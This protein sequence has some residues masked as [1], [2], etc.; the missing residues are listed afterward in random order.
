MNPTATGYEA[1]IMSA[2]NPA[3]QVEVGDVAAEVAAYLEQLPV[4]EEIEAKLSRL[5]H[6]FL[7]SEVLPKA[8]R[9]ASQGIDPTPLLTVVTEVLRLYADALQPPDVAD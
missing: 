3:P 6:G 5:L 8:S 1:I 2:D 4:A 7:E 9:A